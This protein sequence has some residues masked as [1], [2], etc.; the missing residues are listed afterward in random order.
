MI[1]EFIRERASFVVAIITIFGHFFSSHRVIID[2][3]CKHPI[4]L[5]VGV[6]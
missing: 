2:D 5:V 1:A 3:I 4:S 6:S